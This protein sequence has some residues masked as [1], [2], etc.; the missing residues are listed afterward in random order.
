VEHGKPHCSQDSLKFL[1]SERI[2][3]PAATKVEEQGGKG[4]LKKQKLSCNEI[5]RMEQKEKAIE[6]IILL[7][8][9][10]TTKVG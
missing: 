5:D 7:M 4:C 8:Q 2:G 1:F 3:R 10:S 6:Q 9:S